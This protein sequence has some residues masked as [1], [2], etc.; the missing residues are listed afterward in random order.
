MASY[1]LFDFIIVSMRYYLIVWSI[2][3][4]LVKLYL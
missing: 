4:Y 3:Y 1:G 2:F